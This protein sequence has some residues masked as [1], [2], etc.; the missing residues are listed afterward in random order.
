MWLEVPRDLIGRKVLVSQT[1][2]SG[3]GVRPLLAA[4]T[5]GQFVGVFSKDETHV[6]LYRKNIRYRATPNTPR[7]RAVARSFSDS[8]VARVKIASKPHPKTGSVLIDARK[9][10]LR[11]IPGLAR[12]M[13]RLPQKYRF[14]GKSSRLGRVQVYPKNVEVEV[15]A[16][17]QARLPKWTHVLPDSRSLWLTLRY[18]FS[19]LP[20]YG[21]RTRP[22][23]DRVGHFLNS[24]KRYDSDARGTRY[25]RW[26]KRWR[27]RRKHP[28]R[29][30]S[31]PVKPITFWL[32]N[33]IPEEY[34][35]SIRAG[36]LLWNKAFARIGYRNAVVVKQQPANAS[37]GAAD[38][39]YST[40]RW[41]YGDRASFA[42]G[43][44]RYSP[45]TGEIYDADVRMAGDMLM[46]V[47]TRH[48]RFV[49]PLRPSG[50]SISA[51]KL[52]ASPLGIGAPPCDHA[53]GLVDEA[54][55]AHDL[56]RARGGLK[57]G[58]RASKRFLHQFLV[59]LTAHEVGHVLGLRHNFT[60][61]TMLPM[62]K[63]ADT[64]T[65]GKVGLTASVMEYVPANI[66]QKGKRQG[67]Y[68]QITPGPYDYW[69]IEY[70]Y[71]PLSGKTA[72]ERKAE[73]DRIAQKG[74]RPGLAYCTDEDAHRPFGP[75]AVDP[76]CARWD[77]GS[78]PLA[79]YARRANLAREMLD[80]ISEGK[81]VPNGEAHVWARRAFRRSLGR[82]RFSS[83]GAA[84]FIGGMRFRRDHA[85][86]P[87]A[88]LPFK[89]VPAATQ[90]RALA[91][92]DR[93]IFASRTYRVPAKTLRMLAP[94]RHWDFDSRPYS[95]PTDFPYHA[96]VRKAQI[97][98]LQRIYHPVV[99]K[100][101]VDQAAYGGTGLSLH[102]V[103][104]LVHKMVW[105]EA[106]G[107][108]PDIDRHRR[109]LQRSELSLSLKLLLKKG[110]PGE[111]RG[112]ARVLL[113]RLAA[114]LQERL[115]G[116]GVTAVATR[117]HLTD[118]LWRIRSGLNARIVK[119][120]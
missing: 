89:V 24:F 66:S 117:A 102:T 77:L 47:L 49:T 108:A 16:H 50:T 91:F 84:S 118:S 103:L 93:V 10:L 32:E 97:A 29:N 105:K 98:A 52:P 95:R 53:G 6:W 64:A 60:A 68:Y 42:Q 61:S 51:A 41:F 25:V 99:L 26:I 23:D 111:A 88:R 8:L 30:P 20:G 67:H 87:G 4:G 70:A 40:I 59:R 86:T 83:M 62:D 35:A 104:S 94:P 44:A 115:A 18:G 48:V 65:T 56:L 57:P 90:R 101:L 113:T 82:L 54:A 3:M 76:Y 13:R 31:P 36:V 34:R 71:R 1:L 27:L 19:A 9:L 92:L 107:A 78:D 12:I 81:L 74:T 22:G 11:D 7:G 116:K 45:M 38:V 33:T 17:F 43:R 85:K 58:S 2:E 15:R 109:A 114:A 21:F 79:W 39:R 28:E 80:A 110:S 46:R 37:W 120:R 72:A 14:H 63:L 106:Y 100:R 75:K 119:K 96:L 5:I 112:M 73:L 55:F 69:A